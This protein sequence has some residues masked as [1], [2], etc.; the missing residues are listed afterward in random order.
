MIIYVAIFTAADIV[1]GY[2]GEHYYL[3]GAKRKVVLDDKMTL[4]ENYEALQTQL[5]ATHGDD[6]GSH[7]AW[8][9]VTEKPPSLSAL[10]LNAVLSGERVGQLLF[11]ILDKQGMVIECGSY[12]A[13]DYRT[14][15][16]K[17]L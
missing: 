4:Q 12:L 2:V 16:S 10:M 15:E 14:K 1:G 6:F 7:E 13:G 9:N 8:T 5:H 17:P 3:K 11:Y